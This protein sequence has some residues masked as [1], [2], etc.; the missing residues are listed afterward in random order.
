[1]VG[2]GV[3]CCATVITHNEGEG[4][5]TSN[6]KLVIMCK[7]IVSIKVFQVNPQF[8]R[9]I[10]PFS[11]TINF[12]KSKP[13]FS[14]GFT[15]TFNIFYSS[16]LKVDTPIPSSLKDCPSTTIGRLVTP[17]F[18]GSTKVRS[19]LVDTSNIAPPL[20]DFQAITR[21]SCGL[22]CKKYEIRW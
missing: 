4:S 2:K 15:K 18:K 12:F 16:S 11:K 22:A 1:M 20:E 19:D 21:I 3:A 9:K 5:W 8:R 13:I 14:I 6:I 10:Q 7:S 17:D